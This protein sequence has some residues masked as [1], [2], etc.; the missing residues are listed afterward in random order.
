[1]PEAIA[2]VDAGSLARIK[3]AIVVAPLDPM[4]PVS[5]PAGIAGGARQAL[6]VACAQQFQACVEP[7][8]PSS[9]GA[10]PNAG[11]GSEPTAALPDRLPGSPCALTRSATSPAT[12][13]AIRP[14]HPAIRPAPASAR[15]ATS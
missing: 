9:L 12:A 1:V 6:V 3:A 8:V 5:R 10:G 13:L 15:L 2:G 7:P 14:S 4:R 11:V